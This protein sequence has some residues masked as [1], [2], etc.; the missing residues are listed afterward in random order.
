M[1]NSMMK[2]N[3]YF[4]DIPCP[5]CGCPWLHE[6]TV[7]AEGPIGAQWSEEDDEW[8]CGH[9]NEV[10]VHSCMNMQCNWNRMYQFNHG[11]T[12]R[13]GKPRVSIHWGRGSDGGK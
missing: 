7:M 8:V 1:L 9:M 6:K 12:V 11:K 5:R 10:V 13:E 2:A 4:S 3:I